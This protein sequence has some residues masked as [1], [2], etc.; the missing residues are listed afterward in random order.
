M[1]I[2]IFGLWH[3]GCVTAGCVALQFHTIG[4]D[5]DPAT[6]ASL[7]AGKP[8][9]MEPGLGE[10]IQSGIAN[11]KL[12]F[13]TDARAAVQDAEIVWVA[14]D[15]P[16]DEADEA[17]HGYVESKIVSLF[18]YLR[19]GAIVLISSQLPVGSTS[20]I[21]TAYR[22]KY[23]G[24]D[25]HFAYSP[26]NLRLGKAIEVFQ[27]PGRIVI[28]ARSAADRERLSVLLTPFCQ[29]L[30]WM[31]VESAEMTKHALNAFLA[32]SIAFINEVA[33]LCEEV[34]ADSRQVEQGL[35][36]DE[37]IGP[38][39]YLSAGGAFSGGTLA[40]DISFLTLRAKRSGI[41]VPLLESI[42]TS[43]DLHKNWPRRRLKSLLGTL[44]GKTISVLG[45]TYKPGTN[46]LR[47]SAAIE[48]CVWL[49]AQG[50]HVRA[51]D[52]AVKSLPEEL[53]AQITICKSAIETLEDSEAVVIATEWT[54]FRELKSHDVIAHMRTPVVLDASG[55]LRRSLGAVPGLHY[56]AV[57]LAT[58]DA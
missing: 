29:N 48:L 44:D 38:R 3:L 52:P 32:N 37:R 33:T 56:V 25:V 18:P 47:R 17:D 5:P 26:E 20:R 58:E 6:V 54:D 13:T 53:R 24:G 40:R 11:H 27:N 39:A 7:Q 23:P 28:G 57:G 8:P 42:R 4:L 50:A 51:F 46:T 43:N 55:F 22:K 2:C 21:E 12:K 31:S 36:S 35:K 9:I 34:G 15:T 16:V 45:L 49:S 1:T 30:L 10:L 41:P 19:P 14:F